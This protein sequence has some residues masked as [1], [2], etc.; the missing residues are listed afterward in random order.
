MQVDG[1]KEVTLPAEVAGGLGVSLAC[2]NARITLFETVH[3]T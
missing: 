2:T 3:C 1:E